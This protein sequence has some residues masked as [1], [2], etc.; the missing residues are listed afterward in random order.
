MLIGTNTRSPRGTID[1]SVTVDGVKQPLYRRSSDGKVFVVGTPGLAYVLQVTNLKPNRIEVINT[2][3]GRHTLDDEPGDFVANHGLVFRSLSSGSFT[4]WRV[5]DQQTRAFVF[6]SPDRSVAAQ[7]TGSTDN[8][9][10]IGFA[11][12]DEQSFRTPVYRGA[13]ENSLTYGA[14]KGGGM[15][16][17]GGNLGT[18]MGVAQEDRVGRTTFNRLP[19][20]DPDLLVIGYDTEDVLRQQGIIAPAEPNAFPGAQTGYARY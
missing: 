12:Y 10:V 19:G 18:G 17:R 1:V 7:A 5:S 15:R 2:V 11:V 3:D 9:G 6:G 20:V 8:V 16:T 14:S 13:L 4:G